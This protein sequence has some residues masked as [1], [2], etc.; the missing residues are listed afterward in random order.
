MLLRCTGTARFIA[1]LQAVPGGLLVIKRQWRCHVRCGTCPK[2]LKF[3]GVTSTAFSCTSCRDEAA[4]IPVVDA[5]PVTAP[6]TLLGSEGEG[7]E[8]FLAEIR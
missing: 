4:F 7:I 2:G 8:G 6:P 5:I 3:S 1:R